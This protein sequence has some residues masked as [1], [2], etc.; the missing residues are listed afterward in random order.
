M[1]FTA[2]V[3]FAILLYSIFGGLFMAIAIWL[4]CK[5]INTHRRYFLVWVLS[6]IAVFF[7][8]YDF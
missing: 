8:I 6:S 7:L 4:F 3:I 2:I 1:G 5:K